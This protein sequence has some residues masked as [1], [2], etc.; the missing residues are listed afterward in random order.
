M[1]VTKRFYLGNSAAPYSPATFKGAWDASAGTVDKRL[2]NK[3]YGAAATIGIAETN[4]TANWDV[5]LARFVSDPLG[6]D[7]QFTASDT[8]EWVIGVKESN[9]A[10][11]GFSHIHIYVTQ[12]DSNN[13]RGTLLADDIGTT[14]WTTTATGDG[15]G[16]VALAGTV[17][18]I[19]GDRI[20]IEIGYRSV[21][22]SATSR[23]GTINYGNT[24]T[25]DLTDGSTSV[26]T[27]PGWFQ[28]ITATM[29]FPE[30][31]SATATWTC[32]TGIGE[33][34]A[35]VWGGG[36]GGRGAG[37]G[38][39]GGGGGGGAYSLL[40]GIAVVPGNGYTATVGTGGTMGNAGGDSHFVNSSTVLAKGGGSGVAS[41]TGG[42]GGAAGSGIGDTKWSGGNGSTMTSNPDGGKGGGGGGTTANGTNGTANSRTAGG[43][44]GVILGGLGGSGVSF[45]GGGGV[46]G[47]VFGGGGGGQ[48]WAVTEN[49]R[50]GGDG[51]IIL[52]PTGTIS[53]IPN[54]SF[55]YNQA[56]NRASTY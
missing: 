11:D 43:T 31:I 2:T 23:T 5:M 33:V 24:G 36:G 38:N 42:T 25:T 21:E 32:P 39:G 14:E 3:P 4:A 29:V 8:V 13:V 27:Q 40:A 22:A 41:S 46:D 15:D 45:G 18:A 56:V 37:A 26:T 47:V 1:A 30:V 16:A 52:T 44:G 53:N 35:E 55:L 28:F 12:G 17:N 6:I 7:Y 51:G 49:A 9:I 19:A 10:Q 48:D 34:T 54:D 50:A 20:V